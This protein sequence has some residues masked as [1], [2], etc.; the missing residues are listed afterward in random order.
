M[1]GKKVHRTSR[2]VP[3]AL[4]PCACYHQDTCASFNCKQNLNFLTDHV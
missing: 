2:Q 1:E 4:C 3:V